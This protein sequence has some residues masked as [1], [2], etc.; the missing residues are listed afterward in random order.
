MLCEEVAAKPLVAAGEK[1]K[2][3]S[4]DYIQTWPNW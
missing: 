2:E 3:G 4:L 1:S